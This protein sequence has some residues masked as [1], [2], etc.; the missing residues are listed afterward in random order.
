M[1][2]RACGHLES[3]SNSSEVAELNT[4]YGTTA[5]GTTVSY[6]STSNTIKEISPGTWT[7]AQLRDDARVGF[8]IGYYGG[9]VV[10]IT[11]EVTYSIPSSG[12]DYYY[13]YTLTNV[14]ADHIIV[15]DEAGAFIPP[16]ED[17]Q[18]TYY[19]ITISS[20]NATTS[21]ANG[22]TRVQQGTNQVITISPTDP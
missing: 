15:I 10:G 6:T 19:P 2:V 14:S 20:I 7:V 21:P 18:Y 11:W 8:T 17:P 13:T 4:Y 3:T 5:K 22:T 12:G 9:L 16:E 1:S